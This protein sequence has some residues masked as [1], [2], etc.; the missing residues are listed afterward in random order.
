MTK[1]YLFFL[2]FFLLIFVSEEVCS[3]RFQGAIAAGINL[4]QVDGDEVYGFK[5]VGF[6][7]G[8]SIIFPFGK[9]KNWSVT[10]EILFSMNGAYQKGDPAIPDTLPPDTTVPLSYNGYKLNLNYVQIPLM[11]HFTDKKIIA[12]GV[13]FAYNQLV[14]VKEWEDG[15]RQDSTTLRGPYTLADFQVL[16]DVRLRLWRNLWGNIRYSYSILPIRT[17]RFTNITETKVWTRKQYNNVI[18]LR[19]IWIFNDP[20]VKNREGRTRKNSN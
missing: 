3:Q 13:G 8:P 11:V 20:Y 17:R 10:M 7:G 19:L 9:N 2:F 4:S 5:K 1:K 14:S 6:N 12:G 16:A 18:T 15:F